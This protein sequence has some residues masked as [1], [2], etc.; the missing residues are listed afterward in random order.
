MKNLINMNIQTSTSA[1]F[2]PKHKSIVGQVLVALSIQLTDTRYLQTEFSSSL[3]KKTNYST[4]CYARSYSLFNSLTHILFLLPGWQLW[5]YCL[6]FIL[7][8]GSTLPHIFGCYLLHAKM[9]LV[10]DGGMSESSEISV[11]HS[12]NIFCYRGVLWSSLEKEQL[13]GTNLT[14]MILIGFLT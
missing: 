2:L 7:P 3:N 1:A 4:F 11:E 6:Q 10:D 13:P 8:V 9:L 14:S 12:M 5:Y